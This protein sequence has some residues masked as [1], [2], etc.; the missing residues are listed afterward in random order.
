VRKTKEVLKQKALIYNVKT[1]GEEEKSFLIV[2]SSMLKDLGVVRL[3]LNEQNFPILLRGRKN[4]GLGYWQFDCRRVDEQ[5]LA[6]M[7][8]KGYDFT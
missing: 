4:I 7:S 6:T 5:E 1:P 2:D 3:Y 8:N